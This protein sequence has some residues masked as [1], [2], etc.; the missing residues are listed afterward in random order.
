MPSK[1][2]IDNCEGLLQGSATARIK[3]RPQVTG[4]GDCDDCEPWE[5]TV[6]YPKCYNE[7]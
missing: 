4:R 3:S 7:N 1:N 5:L 2:V 6:R